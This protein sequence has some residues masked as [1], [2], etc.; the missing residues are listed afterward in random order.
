M[1]PAA[2]LLRGVAY[3]KVQTSTNLLLRETSA[4]RH[5]LSQAREVVVKKPRSNGRGSL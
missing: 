5:L 3:S 4:L 1:N 2:R